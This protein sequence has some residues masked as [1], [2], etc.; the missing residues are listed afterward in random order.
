M[1][2]ILIL[3]SEMMGIILMEMDDLKIEKSKIFTCAQEEINIIKIF[4]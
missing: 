2:K 3:L 4:V 1:G